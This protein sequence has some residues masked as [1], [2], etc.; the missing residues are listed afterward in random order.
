M[1]LRGD[2]VVAAVIKELPS[3][4][5]ITERELLEAFLKVNWVL[6]KASFSNHELEERLKDL[7]IHHLELGSKYASFIQKIKEHFCIRV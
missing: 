1:I 3:K 6:I 2:G 5:E 4:E 7:L